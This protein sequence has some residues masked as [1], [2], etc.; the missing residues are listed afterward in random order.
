MN[1]SPNATFPLTMAGSGGHV[2]VVSV[3]GSQRN[4]HRLTELGLQ[5]GVELIVL[6]DD[7]NALLIAISDTR[8]ALGYGLAHTVL[9]TALE[10]ND[11][12]V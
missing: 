11:P 10:R 4:A 8:L 7:G 3:T 2:R 9:V 6:R 1:P 5:P 12:H